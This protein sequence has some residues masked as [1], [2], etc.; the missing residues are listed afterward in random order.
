MLADLRQIQFGEADDIRQDFF[1]EVMS[2]LPLFGQ[3]FLFGDAENTPRRGFG[4]S[5]VSG[6]SDVS[7]SASDMA[8]SVSSSSSMDLRSGCC[9]CVFI[10]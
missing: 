5:V 9:C 10:L 7:I 3:T 8:V 6:M 2:E 4:N 1:S